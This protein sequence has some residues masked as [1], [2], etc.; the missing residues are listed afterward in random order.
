MAASPL[1]VAVRSV[2][3]RI[4]NIFPPRMHAALDYARVFYRLPNIDQPQSFNEKVIWRMLYDRDPRF[5]ELADKIKAKE[6]IERK[7]GSDLVIPTLRIYNA[8][9]EMDFTRSPLNKPPYVIKANHG[10]AMNIFVRDDD[11]SFDPRAIKKQLVKFMEFDYATIAEEWAYTAIERKILVEPLIWEPEGFPID[12]KFHVFH[13]RVFATQ[14]IMDR[15]THSRCSVYDR[16]WKLMPLE[17]V[18]RRYKGEIP[19][20]AQWS[21][22][23]EVAETIGQEFA[24]V[25]VDLYAVDDKVRFGELTFYPVGGHGPFWPS[26]WD[27]KFGAQWNES[28]DRPAA[29]ANENKVDSGTDTAESLKK[30]VKP[31]YQ[32]IMNL[33]PA[34]WHVIA[35][36]LRVYHRFP[37][38]KNPRKFSEKIMWRKLYDRDPRLPGL[39]DKIR[40]KDIM[41]KRFGDDFIIPTLGVYNAADELDFSKLPLSQPPYILKTAHGCGTNIIVKKGEIPDPQAI[42]KKLAKYLKFDQAAVAEEWA[43]DHVPRKI[44]AEPYIETPDGD[45]KD[46]KF[47]VFSG[48]VYAIEG[49]ADRFI[50]YGVSFF[51]REWNLLDLRYAGRRY[52][53]YKGVL[54]PPRHLAQM[55]ARAEEIGRDFSYIR[56]DLYEV[57]DQIKLGELTFYP[58]AGHDPF[59][60]SAWDDKFGQQWNLE[61]VSTRKKMTERLKNFVKPAYQA[62]MQ[63]LPPRLNVIAGYLQAHYRLPDLKNPQSFSDKIAWRKLYDRDPRLP[64]LVDKIR[65]K[66]IMSERFGHDFVI[67]TLRVYDSADELD[68]TQPP[69][70]QPPYVIKVNHSSAMN[71]FVR[72]GDGSFDPRSIKRKLAAFLK[73]NHAALAQEWAYA[74]VR[75]RIFVEPLIETPQGYL[76]D[77]RFHVFDG[78]TYAIETI[79]DIYGPNRRENMYDRDWQLLNVVHGRYPKYDQPLPRP[80]HL[81]EM[82]QMAESIGK[83]F[84]Y[85]RVDLYEINGTI[86]FGELT[87]YPGAGH[88]TFNPREW[89]DKF[90]RQWN[91]DTVARKGRLPMSV[92]RVEFL[93]LPLDLGLSIESLCQELRH[94]G[95]PRLMG[96]I[97]PSSWAV[98]KRNPE[99]V[100]A[101]RQMTSIRAGGEGVAR[102]CQWLMDVRCPRISFD[103]TSLADPFFKMAIA[104]KATVMLIGGDPGVDEQMQDKLKLNYPELNVVATA[105][106]YDEFAPK[107]A[108]VQQYAPDVVIVGMGSPRQEQFLIALRGAGYKGLAIACGGFFDQYLEAD[109]YY[110]A[111]I[112][113]WN[114]RF[115]WRFYKEPRRLWRRYLIDYQFFVWE[116][117]KALAGKYTPARVKQLIVKEKNT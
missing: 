45:L 93:G 55:I 108:A 38:L 86:K 33:L 72:E 49:V 6:Y 94:K 81:I 96:Y 109:D 70:S 15:S 5:P 77:F 30:A 82:L 98:A 106:G 95:E 53:P 107:I 76:P 32:G 44:L 74:Q 69:L 59:F 2:Y 14:V 47:H 37:D 52:P 114:L 73:F 85:V 4:M 51:D 3:R 24:Y 111:W 48:R 36:Y 17:Y 63:I 117:L 25:R 92:E 50:N 58:S 7:F 103:M 115:A 46:Y 100:E 41:G 113:R 28:F 83:D 19:R 11:G 20:P 90:G 23:V 75:P 68:F 18:Y 102:A 116:A 9:E 105:H 65:V 89:D 1:K 57:G 35:D 64:E 39:V 10:C 99:F 79:L 97:S 61:T 26:E 101:L 16:D 71:I 67:P 22:M 112:D 31:F 62:V 60:P 43:Y 88:E 84:S 104:E 91:L 56:V 42:K 34:R 21:R 12:Y 87:F 27:G 78:R 110:P 8:V 54:P 13:G 29:A 40:V 80:A 66:E